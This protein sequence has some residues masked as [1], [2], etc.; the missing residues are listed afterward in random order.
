MLCLEDIGMVLSL[1]AMQYFIHFLKFVSGFAII[2]A[3]SLMVM[4]FVA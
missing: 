1:V 4:R 3:V 2:L